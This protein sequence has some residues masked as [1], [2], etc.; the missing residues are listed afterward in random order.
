[1][2]IDE[3]VLIM[4]FTSIHRDIIA[5]VVASPRMCGG[6]SYSNFEVNRQEQP[7]KYQVIGGQIYRAF[8]LEIVMRLTQQNK[9]II[10]CKQNN[11]QR[12]RCLGL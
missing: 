2:N 12:N 1:M 9:C 11:M 10:I 3:V 5:S 8:V 7:E 4:R 6:V